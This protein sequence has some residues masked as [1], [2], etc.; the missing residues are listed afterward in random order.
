MAVETTVVDTS[1]PVA[2][3]DVVATSVPGETTEAPGSTT[4]ESVP[5][6]TLPEPPEYDLTLPALCEME[7]G[8]AI[9]HQNESVACLEVR[10]AQVIVGPA[11]FDV[12]DLFDEDTDIAVRQFQRANGV[13]DDGIVGPV[14]ASL[15][16]IWPAGGVAPTT[17]T[18]TTTTAG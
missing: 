6:T 17:T 10:L 12:D 15:L 8:V 13:L 16:G 1:E 2:A 3:T 4:A 5:E 9:Q 11:A 14:T 18:T 7:I